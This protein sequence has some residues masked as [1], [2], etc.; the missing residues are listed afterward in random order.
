MLG[1]KKIEQL[2]TKASPSLTRS[3]VVNLQDPTANDLSDVRTSVQTWLYDQ[4][5]EPGF[6]DS[7]TNQIEY[8][9]GLNVRNKDKNEKTSEAWQIASYR[10][11]H[12]Y[13]E[14]VDAVSVSLRVQRGL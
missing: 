12:H 13:D 8:A 11:S 9:T 1:P 4:N 14:H 3:L 10:T 7:L 2:I 6:F 5:Q